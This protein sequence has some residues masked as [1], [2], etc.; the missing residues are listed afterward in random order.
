MNSSVPVLLFHHVAPDRAIT[1]AVFEAQLRYLID[2][3][4]PRL[5][6]EDLIKIL[7]RER[8]GLSHRLFSRSMTG[9]MTISR[10]HGRFWRSCECPPPFI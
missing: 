8:H 3:E 9:T 10:S 2:R 1:P 5:S 7:R 6:L 4:L